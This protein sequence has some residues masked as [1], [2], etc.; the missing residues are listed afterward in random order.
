MHSLA[1]ALTLTLTQT[2]SLNHLANKQLRS[3]QSFYSQINGSAADYEQLLVNWA[4]VSEPHTSELNRDF[5]SNIICRTSFRI[6][7]TL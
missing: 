4:S 2:L 1:P 5:S 6:F 3:S 7:L